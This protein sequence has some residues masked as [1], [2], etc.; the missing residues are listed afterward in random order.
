MKSCEQEQRVVESR[1]PI[2]LS[3]GRSSREPRATFGA[4]SDA[5]SRFNGERLF[6]GTEAELMSD[7]LSGGR[8]ISNL[9]PKPP[10]DSERPRPRY[11][12]ISVSDF[13]ELLTQ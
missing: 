11:F 3:I 7:E 9:R 13:L 10:A 8:Q 1:A 2:V 12:C 6:S 4:W 5:P